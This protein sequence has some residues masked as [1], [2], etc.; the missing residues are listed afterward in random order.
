MD[1][2]EILP[3][4]I[5]VSNIALL[6]VFHA[7]SG[8]NAGTVWPAVEQISNILNVLAAAEVARHI[9]RF[10][11]FITEDGEIEGYAERFLDPVL[12]EKAG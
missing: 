7:V 2:V 8:W 10:M 6:E 9:E 12:V 4:A 11:Y 5:S 3:V 1:A